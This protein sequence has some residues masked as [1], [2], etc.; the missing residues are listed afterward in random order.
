[1][2]PSDFFNGIFLPV[3]GGVLVFAAT[4]TGIVEIRVFLRRLNRGQALWTRRPPLYAPDRARLFPAILMLIIG[5]IPLFLMCEPVYPSGM[6]QLAIVRGGA[7]FVPLL[8][9][10]CGLLLGLRVKRRP[11]RT[12]LS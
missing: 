4:F 2:Q 9:Q 10:L 7:A 3:F 11:G 1:M 6:K 5:A 8:C 12:H